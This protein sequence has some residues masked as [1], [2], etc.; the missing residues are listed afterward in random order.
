MCRQEAVTSLSTCQIGRLFSSVFLMPFL[1][2][3][4]LGNRHLG[5]SLREEAN[6]TSGVETWEALV[7]MRNLQ[8]PDSLDLVTF[9]CRAWPAQTTLRKR[10]KGKKDETV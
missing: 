9:A 8:M 2:S 1:H 4:N 7:Q 6:N 10:D 5:C 3:W